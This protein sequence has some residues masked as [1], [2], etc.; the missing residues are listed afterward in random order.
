[1]ATFSAADLSSKPRH[2]GGHGNAVVVYGSVTPAAGTLGD[3]YRPVIIPAGVDVTDVD[4]VS[5]DL[6][7][8][9]TPAMACKVGYSPLSPEDGPMADDDYFAPA[10]TTL[11]RN[12]GRTSLAFQPVRFEKPV[13][14]IITLTAS[15]ATFASGKVTAIVKGDGVG[16][17]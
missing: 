10:G 16:I 17:R 12:A 9:G 1:M 14:L 7:S 13:Y 15:S 5:D 2:M 8:S 3:V 11:L 4:I 6:D